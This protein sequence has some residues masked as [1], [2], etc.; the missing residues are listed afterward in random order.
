MAICFCLVAIEDVFPV[1]SSRS[2]LGRGIQSINQPPNRCQNQI[3]NNHLATTMSRAILI[4]GD[5]Q[6][7]GCVYESYY[8]QDRRGDGG[9]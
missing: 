9:L 1:L 4:R 3:I 8:E 5:S 2:G 7:C 6:L